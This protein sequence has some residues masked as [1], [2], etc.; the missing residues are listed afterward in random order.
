MKPNI[1][2]FYRYR[3]TPAGPVVVSTVGVGDDRS[4]WLRIEECRLSKEAALK[5]AEK[6]SCPVLF[7]YDKNHL[8]IKAT[9]YVET[10]PVLE[11]RKTLAK[12]FD[13]VLEELQLMHLT[14]FSL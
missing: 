2:F 3:N 5:I 7:Y 11:A 12:V 8:F 4:L 14:H 1:K 6:Y 10:F 9:V 13:T